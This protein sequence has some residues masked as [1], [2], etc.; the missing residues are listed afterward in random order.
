MWGKELYHT[1]SRLF[2][3]S[4][5]VVVRIYI[6]YIPINSLS[7]FCAVKLVELRLKACACIQRKWFLFW[8]CQFCNERTIQSRESSRNTRKKVCYPSGHNFKDSYLLSCCVKC[9]YKLGRSHKWTREKET[10]LMHVSKGFCKIT[11]G[12]IVIDGYT[13]KENLQGVLWNLSH[14]AA[15]W[16]CLFCDA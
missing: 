2:I 6:L 3:T 8:R 15:Y 4:I 1:I 13:G 5:T 14:S 9:M 11:V 7:R 16:S 12:M 10:R